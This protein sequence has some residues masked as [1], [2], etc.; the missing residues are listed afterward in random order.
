M[1]FLPNFQRCG[2]C[3]CAEMSNSQQT[4]LFLT[5]VFHNERIFTWELK[6][7]HRFNDVGLL[8]LF[9]RHGLFSPRPFPFVSRN[10]RIKLWI[11]RFWRR[12]PL[13]LVFE[14]WAFRKKNWLTFLWTAANLPDGFYPSCRYCSTVS[15]HHKG[16]KWLFPCFPKSKWSLPLLP[17]SDSSF[18]RLSL[19]ST[20][21]TNL[22][23]RTKDFNQ[24]TLC[25]P[26]PFC[27]KNI[28][29][30]IFLHR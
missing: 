22:L 24:T 15:S 27:T 11:W 28:T 4:T 14:L 16:R 23:K 30:L 9:L 10:S 5:P 1:S 8:F 25:T 12:E 19:F 18:E 3:Y 21:K 7:I 2:A 17:K 26:V 20:H 13:V 6:S 29:V